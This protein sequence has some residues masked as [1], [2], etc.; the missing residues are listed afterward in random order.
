MIGEKPGKAG[1]RRAGERASYLEELNGSIDSRG[2]HGGCNMG[3][4][5]QPVGGIG[6]VRPPLQIEPG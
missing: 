4:S 5:E 6:Q 2:N 3:H 1:K